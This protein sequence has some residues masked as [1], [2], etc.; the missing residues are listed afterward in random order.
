[1]DATVFGLRAGHCYRRSMRVALISLLVLLGAWTQTAEAAK[2]VVAAIEE[3]AAD[4]APLNRADIHMVAVYDDADGDAHLCSDW[5]IWKTAPAEKVWE[6]PCATGA[7]KV[8]IHLGDGAFVGSYAGRKA[9]EPSTAYEL[10]V[11][12]RDDSGSPA[13]EWSEWAIRA[14]T[15]AEPDPGGTDSDLPW[16]PRT[17]YAVEVFASDLQLPVNVA[18][19]PNPGPHPGDP[20]LYVT[21]L[22]GTVKVVT[23]DG[24]VSDYETDLLDFNPTGDFPGSGEQGLTGIAVDPASGD[25]FVSLVYED[26]TSSQNPKPH[27]PKVLRLH[28]DAEGMEAIGQ[29]TV[30]DMEG[31][32]Q[33]A[34]H[35]ISNLTISPD[36]HL[37]VHNGDGFNSSTGQNLEAFRGKVLRMTLGGAPVATNPFYDDAEITARDYV[38]AYGLRNPFGG[39]WRLS[40]ATHWEVENG[41]A[42]DRLAPV[43]AGENY[44]WSIDQTMTAHASYNWPV[45]H[46][47]VSIDFVEPPRFGGSGFPPVAMG[48]AFVTESGPTYAEGP[49]TRGKRIVEFDLAPDGDLVAGPTTLVEYT[50]IG[51]ATAAGLAAGPG[52]LYFTDLY[53]DT[54]AETPIDRGAQVL[55]VRYCGACLPEPPEEPELPEEPEEPG[56]GGTGETP[57]G[58]GTSS[59][60]PVAGPPAPS[61]PP[62]SLTRFRLLRSVFAV[63]HSTPGRAGASVATGTAFLYTLSEFATV[64]IAIRRLGPGARGAVGTLRGRGARGPNRQPFGGRLRGRPLQPGRYEATIHARDAVGNVATPARARFRVVPGS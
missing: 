45:S 64:R 59:T 54:E 40:D 49:Q 35:Q 15:T 29:S 31:E 58:S 52:G 42:V 62:P 9:L 30:I 4:A 36:G 60:A 3:P 24:T 43:L 28:S 46:A 20:L 33:G 10:R 12:F 2:P 55:L 41:P 34:S 39:A 5:E 51:H 17:G 14:F 50:G 53:K 57:G 8:H 47:P 1:M 27:Y 7:E 21:E 18:M 32:E 25:V 56:G 11:R 22:Y 63:D 48:H 44:G 13:E 19:V 6:A 23:R 37:F 26:E 16:K 38:F 61:D